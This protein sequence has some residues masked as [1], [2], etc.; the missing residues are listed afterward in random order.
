MK[1]INARNLTKTFGKVQ[2]VRG[3]NLEIESGEIFGLLGPNGAGKTTTVRMLAT[4]LLPTGGNVIIDGYRLGKDNSKIKNIIGVC[5]QDITLYEDLTGEENLKY[6]ASLYKVSRHQQKIRI[7]ELLDLV[8]LYK[9]RNRLVK[10]YS[11]GMK[12]RLQI[13]RALVSDPKILFLDEPTLGLSPESRRKVWD[14]IK[15]LVQ[16][17]NIAILLTT[18]YLEE[19]DQLTDKVAII[20]RGR[21]IANAKPEDLKDNVTLEQRLQII[22][23]QP[24][25]AFDILVKKGLSVNMHHRTI[26]IS[27]NNSV[28]IKDILPRLWNKE[29][30]IEEISMKRPSLEDA[31]L[32]LTNNS[33][34][35]EV[36]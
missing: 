20:D 28:S 34:S 27:M 9:D 25:K 17:R 31:F 18:H 5:S 14:Y 16:E 33:S 36:I 21:I 11:G 32:K 22:C 4:S 23:D 8:D 30:E 2:A 26:I 6:H 12:R 35:V 3:V 29:I 24:E 13:A 1:L 19:A 7:K 15:Q 10:K